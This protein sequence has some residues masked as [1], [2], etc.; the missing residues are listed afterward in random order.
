MV[1]YAFNVEVLT[2]NPE[3]TGPLSDDDLADHLH[4]AGLSDAM[5]AQNYSVFTVLVDRQASSRAEAVSSALQDLTKIPGVTVMN[6]EFDEEAKTS[7]MTDLAQRTHNEGFAAGRR[8]LAMS[9]RHHVNPEGSEYVK[10][11]IEDY[12]K[13][14]FRKYTKKEK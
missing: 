3:G 2:E 14:R 11:A 1:T 9:V 5:L 6:I 8:A 12:E 7:T 13:P 4:E 10:E